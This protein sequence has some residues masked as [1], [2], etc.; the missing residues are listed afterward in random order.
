MNI[1]QSIFGQTE[2]K[3][4]T[5]K[6][7][8]FFKHLKFDVKYKNTN[9]LTI[10][11]GDK[12]IDIYVIDT[13]IWKTMSKPDDKCKSIR[14]Q[15]NDIH[16]IVVGDIFHVSHDTEHIPGPIIGVNIFDTYFYNV[17]FRECHKCKQICIYYDKYIPCVK[18]GKCNYNKISESQYRNIINALYIA[19]IPINDRE[20]LDSWYIMP[21]NLPV[22]DID[23]NDKHKHKYIYIL[24]YK[25]HLHTYKVSSCSN[26][27]SLIWNV[28]EQYNLEVKYIMESSDLDK[29]LENLYIL[30]GAVDG[31]IWGV[32]ISSFAPKM[33]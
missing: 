5:R 25:G 19:N 21:K 18:C 30:N 15:Y 23:I 13:C 24:E 12:Y 1:L 9:S 20:T 6:W 33:T 2:Y 32:H 10:T 4:L 14:N 31:W 8:T 17:S 22:I 29:V 16:T 27:Q 26:V 7:Y 11:I 28:V 3:P